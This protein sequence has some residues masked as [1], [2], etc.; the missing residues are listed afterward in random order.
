MFPVNGGV[1]GEMFVTAGLGGQALRVEHLG[2]RLLT[3]L[4]F[5]ELGEPPLFLARAI[6]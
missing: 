4:G 1:K 3:N 5:L 2:W 6:L